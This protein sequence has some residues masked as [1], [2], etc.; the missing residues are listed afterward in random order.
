MIRIGFN[1]QQLFD[2]IMAVYATGTVEGAQQDP[3]TVRR[4]E[5]LLNK[6][7]RAFDSKIMTPGTPAGPVR[8]CM[9]HEPAVANA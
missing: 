4:R 9:R 6:L 2:L 8:M 7:H 5:V 1:E 3:E